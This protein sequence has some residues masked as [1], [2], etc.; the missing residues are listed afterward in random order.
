MKLAFLVSL[1]SL[2]I[3][4]GYGVQSGPITYYR[5]VDAE[6]GVVCYTALVPGNSVRVP[7][8]QCLKIK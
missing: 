7:T 2:S 1:F 5:Y 6:L 3:S 8:M 4:D